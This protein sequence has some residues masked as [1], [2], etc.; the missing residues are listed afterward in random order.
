MFGAFLEV[1]RDLWAFVLRR[2]P[3]SAPSGDTAPTAPLEP[4][5]V[6]VDTLHDAWSTSDGSVGTSSLRPAY[7]LTERARCL[8]HPKREFDGVLTTFCY[9]D[10]VG[11]RRLQDGYAEVVRRNISGWVDAS[12]LTDDEASVFPN[13]IPDHQYLAT[14]RETRKARAL[15]GDI[16]LGATLEVPLTSLEYVLSELARR[17]IVVDWPLERPRTPGVLRRSLEGRRGI[18]IGVA[19]R[20]AALIE[21]PASKERGFFGMVEA[22]QPD[23]G[24]RIASVGRVVEGEFRREHFSLQEWRKWN[25]VFITFS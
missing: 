20:T 1:L 2:E 7:V 11:V 25:P 14:H 17:R 6:N 21:V 9:G 10:R 18:T 3:K 12:E 23:Q 5:G 22:V 19:P 15:I 4:V 24:I 13:L 8:I 16:C